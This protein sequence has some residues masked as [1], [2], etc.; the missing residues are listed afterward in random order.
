MIVNRAGDEFLPRAAFAGDKD[1]ATG[2]R[3]LFD[4]CEDLEHLFATRDGLS[5]LGAAFE[6]LLKGAT[7]FVLSAAT[8]A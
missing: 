2:R 6:S 4:K 5:R 8:H 7:L 1:R 3:Y